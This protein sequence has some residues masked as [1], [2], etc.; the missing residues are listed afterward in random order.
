MLSRFVARW[1]VT[2]VLAA[3]AVGCSSSSSSGGAP[4]AGPGCPIDASIATF[5]FPDASLGD[6]GGSA[7]SCGAC[8]N[9]SCAAYVAACDDDCACLEATK[10]VLECG[11]D[12][13]TASAC[14]T[15]YGSSDTNFGSLAYCI[16]DFCTDPCNLNGVVDA[17]TDAAASS[18][19]ASTDGALDA[20][21]PSDAAISDAAISDAAI[22]DATPADATPSD[23]ASVSDGAA[24]SDGAAD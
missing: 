2:A 17:G 4:E 23:A 9:G 7:L 6:A 5:T 10:S 19:A 21:A 13:G 22:S 11:Q 14:A 20:A 24:A 15:M 12:G 8:L 18:D 16:L 3:V 1:G